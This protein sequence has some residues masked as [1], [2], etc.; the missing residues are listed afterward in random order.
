[1]GHS[2]AACHALEGRVWDGVAAGAEP[3]L[4]VSDS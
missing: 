1:M 4:T 3:L 2:L